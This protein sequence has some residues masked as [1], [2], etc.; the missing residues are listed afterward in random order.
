M[1]KMSSNGRSWQVMTWSWAC[2]TGH[3]ASDRIL[4][5]AANAAWPYAQ[6]CAW[7]FMNDDHVAHDLMEHAIKNAAQYIARNPDVIA[8]KVNARVKS[9]VRREAKRLAAK[10]QRESPSGSAL[11]FDSVL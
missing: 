4:E 2:S 11:D 10:R 7:T 8:R 1:P 9:E 6:L 5:A 3:P